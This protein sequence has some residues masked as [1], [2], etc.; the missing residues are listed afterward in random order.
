VAINDTVRL[1]VIGTVNGT[2]H[3]HTLHARAMNADNPAD[4]FITLWQSSCLAAYRG[5]FRLLEQP[6]QQIKAAVVCGTVPLPAGSELA[7]AAGS[8]SGTVDFQGTPEPAYMAALVSVKSNLAG[9]RRQGRF[10]IGGLGKNDTAGNLLTAACISRL[11]GYVDAVKAAFV[12]PAAPTVKL[13]VH[14][15]YLSTPHPAYTDR[16]GVL[17]PAYTPGECQD[18]SALVVNLIVSDRATTMRSRKLGH[19]L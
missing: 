19:G 12:T 16:N 3:V 8:G 1:S 14:S 5:A 10:F 6:V 17:I 9:R 2:Q 11:Q 18:S 7:I 13:V 4:A 15:R